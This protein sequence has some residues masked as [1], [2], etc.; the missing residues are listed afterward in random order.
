MI[1]SGVVSL[2]E[3]LDLNAKQ[4]VGHVVELEG[5]VGCD[6]GAEN[7][8]LLSGFRIGRRDAI[9]FYWIEGDDASVDGGVAGRFC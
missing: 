3:D 7:D 4:P 2:H 1:I 6:V 5:A 8:V 9:V